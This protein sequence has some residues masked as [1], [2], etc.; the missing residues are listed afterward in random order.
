MR[1]GSGS[2]GEEL[3]P[4]AEPSPKTPSLD[5]CKSW[6]DPHRLSLW[7]PQHWPHRQ[8]ALGPLCTQNPDSSWETESGPTEGIRS[9]G[10]CVSVE[11]QKK[12]GSR[13]HFRHHRGEGATSGLALLVAS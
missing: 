3:V 7:R 2:W 6:G 12:A 10:T 13:W 5:G 4:R 8:P 9:W 11:N 1:L